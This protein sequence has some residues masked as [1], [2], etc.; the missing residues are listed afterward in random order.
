MK[1]RPTVLL[2]GHCVPDSIGL[3]RL[4][5]RA[6]PGARVRRVN[7]DRAL[8]KQ[9]T[10]AA[11]LLVNRALDGRFSAEDGVEMIAVLTRE[12]ASPTMMLVSNYP[13]AQERA[14]TAGARPGF[15][16]RDLRG[17]NTVRMLRAALGGAQHPTPGGESLPERA[18]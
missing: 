16:K 4:V 11:L 13:D 18:V 9:A 2:V 1:D 8:A 14:V 10:A 5:K 15:G 3:S 12:G 17:E 6:A 7:S